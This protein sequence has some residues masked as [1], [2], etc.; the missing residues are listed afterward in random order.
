M[1]AGEQRAQLAAVS[2]LLT[3]I[4]DKYLVVFETSC[5]HYRVYHSAS[6]TVSCAAA[7]AA[8]ATHNKLRYTPCMYLDTPLL[9]T[10][11]CCC[12]PLSLIM[13]LARP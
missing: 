5:T 13:L 1:N 7:V 11:L 2:A 3:H 6:S 8:A 9:C 4:H 10:V 12:L